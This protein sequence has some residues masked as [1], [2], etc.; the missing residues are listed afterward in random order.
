MALMSV[1]TSPRL[2]ALDMTEGGKL[3]SIVLS[4]LTKY[5][6]YVEP[7]YAAELD[8]PEAMRAAAAL[9]KLMSRIGE[10]TKSDYYTYTGPIETTSDSIIFKPFISTSQQIEV[11][12]RNGMAEVPMIRRRFRTGLDV[13]SVINKLVMVTKYGVAGLRMVG[14]RILRTGSKIG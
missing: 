13:G 14:V 12:I 11:I 2:Y 7:G 4:S 8:W 5:V 6:L 9:A 1:V 10:L 3:I